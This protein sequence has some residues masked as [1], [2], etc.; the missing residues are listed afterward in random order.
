MTFHDGQN[1]GDKS[2]LGESCLRYGTCIAEKNTFC[3][4]IH[5]K[6]YV[7]VLRKANQEKLNQI[8][9]FLR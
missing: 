7:K 9:R 5:G 3:V 6:I 4:I 8:T 1:F 2:M